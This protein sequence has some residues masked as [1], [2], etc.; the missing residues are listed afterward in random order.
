MWW[1]SAIEKFFGR[2]RLYSSIIGTIWMMIYVTFRILGLVLYS[3][4][5]SL[6]LGRSDF[7]CEDGI[8]GEVSP[9]CALLCSDIYRPV[10][11]TRIY[12]LQLLCV[13]FAPIGFTSYATWV[14]ARARELDHRRQ[15]STESD[16]AVQEIS[17]L[18]KQIGKVRTREAVHSDKVITVIWTRKI[19]I[20]FVIQLLVKLLIESFFFLFILMLQ[21]NQY[22]NPEDQSLSSSVKSPRTFICSP[23]NSLLT[24]TKSEFDALCNETRPIRCWTPNYSEQYLFRCY[25]LFFT[26]LS[27]L[28]IVIELIYILARFAKHNPRL[29]FKR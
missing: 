5:R 7:F 29:K 17:L 26:S 25:M 24:L 6:A 3:T 21:R 20:A 10:S 23:S 14:S 18:E 19:R 2:M 15:A 28:L 4:D 13:V 16:S 27:V 8:G 22:G 11:E 9:K 1:F 12:A